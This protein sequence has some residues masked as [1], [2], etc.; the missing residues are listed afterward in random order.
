[1]PLE[2]FAGILVSVPWSMRPV[3]DQGLQIS[4]ARSEPGSKG[5]HIDRYIITE[6]N[7][8]HSIGDV[9]FAVVESL[10]MTTKYTVKIKTD[11][12]LRDGVHLSIV[13]YADVSN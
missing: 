3:L 1:M 9:T 8:P 7:L 10:D 4:V 13:V 2:P 6:L 11:L 5:F 12:S